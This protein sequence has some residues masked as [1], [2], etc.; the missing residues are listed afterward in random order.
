ML[1]FDSNSKDH[2]QDLVERISKKVDINDGEQTQQYFMPIVLNW[3]KQWPHP[4]M[5]FKCWDIVLIWIVMKN[6]FWNCSAH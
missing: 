4:E 6:Q 1:I 2:L 3:N 5:K